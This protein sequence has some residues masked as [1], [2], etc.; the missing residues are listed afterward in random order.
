MTK[1]SQLRLYTIE[2]GKLG[3]F[4]REWLQGVYPLRQKHGFRVDGAWLIKDESKFAWILSYEGPEEWEAV[5]GAYYTSPERARLDPDPV[6]LIVDQQH[7]FVSSVL[8][9]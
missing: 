2:E 3:E 5:D 6:R 4:V 7:W 1:V 9:E 8:P